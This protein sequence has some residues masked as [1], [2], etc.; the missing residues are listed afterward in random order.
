MCKKVQ[1][2]LAVEAIDLE[3]VWHNLVC[4]INRSCK[5]VVK[6]FDNVPDFSEHKYNLRV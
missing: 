5:S 2:Q 3:L 4:R 1:K 6:M